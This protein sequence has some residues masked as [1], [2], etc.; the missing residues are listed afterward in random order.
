MNCGQQG[1]LY[2]SLKSH[3]W[4]NFRKEIIFDGV[5]DSDMV[6]SMEEQL[7]S[8]YMEMG[9]SLNDRKYVK[10]PVYAEGED[11][12]AS[13]A[14]LK[15]NDEGDIIERY[16]N[17]TKAAKEIGV[18]Q[19]CISRAC[20]KTNKSAGFYW[21]FEN[22]FS[23]EGFLKEKNKPHA[24]SKPIVQTTKSGEF[25]KIWQSQHEA[26]KETGVKQ[27]NIWRCLSGRSIS[28]GGF[29]WFYEADFKSGEVTPRE[30]R[31]NSE[32]P[33]KATDVKL[34]YVHN[35]QSIIECSRSL[36]INRCTIARGC[37]GKIKKPTKF[38]FEYDN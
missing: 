17:G 37:E 13:K 19:T 18:D 9:V 34:G 32:K 35:F 14:V 6:D 11:H 22:G 31:R 33:V 20:I 24:L 4:N 15:V 21:Q 36:G 8:E 7:I 28:A 16:V 26:S 5:V 2:S 3:G 27:C 23:K 1:V 10:S 25:I 38:I 12:Y 29:C 30:K